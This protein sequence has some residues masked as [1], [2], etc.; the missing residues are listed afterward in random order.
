MYCPITVF[1]EF[2]KEYHYHKIKESAL[3]VSKITEIREVI[4]FEF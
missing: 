1:L 3:R 2:F 4:Y